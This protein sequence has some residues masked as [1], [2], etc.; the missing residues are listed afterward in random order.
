MAGIVSYG[1]HVPRYRLTGQ[2][3]GSAWGNPK[4]KGERA[5]ANYDEDP[6]TMG[7]SAMHS[8]LESAGGIPVAKLYLASTSMPYLEKG[9]A[10]IIGPALDLPREIHS[11]DF[12]GSLRAG[13]TAMLSALDAVTAGSAGAVLMAAAD[14]RQNEPGLATELNVGDGAAGFVIGGKD[15]IAEVKDILSITRE[16]V[17]IWRREGDEYPHEED[18]RFVRDYAFPPLLKETAEKILQKSGVAKEKISRIVYPGPDA[19]SLKTFQKSLKFDEKCYLDS[20]LYDLVGD[21]GAAMQPLLLIQALEEAKPG[22]LILWIAYGGGSDA[23]LFEVTKKIESFPNRGILKKQLAAKRELSSYGKFLQFKGQLPTEK[24]N[25]FTSP[26]ILNR[27]EASV[28]RLHG[29]TCKK[30]GESYFPPRRVCKKCRSKDEFDD[31]VLG[32][33]GKVFTFTK[34]HLPPTPDPPVIMASSDMEGGGRFYGQIT[35]CDP[36]SVEVG[37][38]VELTFRRLHEG[39]GFINYFWKQMPVL[40]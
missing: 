5:V 18:A 21:A 9:N 38:E 31:F 34:D 3:V 20:T 22:D 37:M 12:A 10:A 8:A 23:V 13:A 36:A 26:M 32:R 2:A 7:W 30:C 17:D 6:I 1:V 27:E 25:P 16:V 33:R 28:Y 29:V 11:A 35:D 39:G 4:L 40:K 15:T 14:V 24:V 19:R